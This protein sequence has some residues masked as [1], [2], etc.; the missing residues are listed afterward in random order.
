MTLWK[1]VAGITTLR[2]Q[3]NARFP[4]RDK[5]SDGIVGDAS[6]QARPSDHNPDSRGYVHAMDIDEDFGAKGDNMKFANQILD[7]CRQGR[8]GSERIKYVVYEDKVASGTYSGNFWVWRGSGYG[9]QHH[10]HI[11]FTT[12]GEQ[13]DAPFDIPILQKGAIW[14]GIIP[15][16]SEIS[17]S[18]GDPNVRNKATYRLACRLKDK[19]FY[20]GD[21]QPLGEQG[22]PLK[23]VMAWEKATGRKDDGVFTQADQRALFGAVRN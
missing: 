16:M 18:M 6:H 17:R 15:K 19:G 1:P 14:D 9:H 10:I 23:A 13:D 20:Q 2:N 11:S 12:V 7:Y 4:K 3:V 5:A 8:K 21:V 22:Y